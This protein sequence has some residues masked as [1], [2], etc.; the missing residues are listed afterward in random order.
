MTLKPVTPA[1][2]SIV[3][4]LLLLIPGA[5]AQPSARINS[6]PIPEAPSRPPELAVGQPL[7]PFRCEREFI[8]QGERI[9][10]DTMI[11]QDGERLRPIIR[12]VPEAVAELDQYQ[13][14]R[15]NIRSAAYI[16]TAGILVM[17]AGSLLGRVNRETSSF[18]RNFVTYGGLTLTAGTVLYGISTLQSN[19]AHLG[20]AVRIYNEHRPNR[21]IELQFTT[22]VSF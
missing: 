19:E 7:D 9:Q 10:C 4:C 15:R 3:C 12:E 17:I 2:I 14:N 16:G 13:R 18:T 6:G 1:C 8:Y 11:R 5:N 22:D 21:P 20:N